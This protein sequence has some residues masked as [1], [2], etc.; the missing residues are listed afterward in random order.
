MQQDKILK[1]YSKRLAQISLNEEG[2]VD[3]ERVAA[4]LECLKQEP[5]KGFRK[6][7]Q[8][9]KNYIAQALG[10]THATIEHAGNIEASTVGTIQKALSSRFDR[11]I[12]VSSSSNPDLIAGIRVT[13]ADHVWEQSVSNSLKNLLHQ[14]L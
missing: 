12:Q 10:N 14:E 11:S 9:Y 4:V 8:H 13:L 5:P 2:A 1:K 6:I 7:L 3:G